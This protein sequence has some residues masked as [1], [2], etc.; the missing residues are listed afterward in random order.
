MKRRS[1]VIE[2][3]GL[4]GVGKSTLSHRVAE[5]L[6]QRGWRVDQPTYAVDHEMRYWERL[7]LKLMRVSAEVIFH[8]AHALRSVRAIL[9]TRQASAA[10]FIGVTVNWLFVSSLLRKSDRRP[11]VHIF[12]EGLFNVLWSIGFSAS[13]PRTAPLL[14]ELAREGSTAVVALIEADV[15]AIRERLDLRKHGQSRLERAGATDDSWEQAGRALQQVKATLQ[16]LADEGAD[17]RMVAVRNA[18]G[19]NLDALANR[20]ATTFEEWLGSSAPRRTAASG[21]ERASRAGRPAT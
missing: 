18:A 17:A 2:F 16:M 10:D 20:L 13:S 9:A 5:I 11:G 8:P 15:A 19:E 6:G 12:D 14:K 7:L 1:A 4:P 21:I 3:I